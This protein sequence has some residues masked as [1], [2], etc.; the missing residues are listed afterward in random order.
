MEKSK[1]Y[2]VLQL[3]DVLRK[4]GFLRIS[5]CCGEYAISVATFRRYVAFLRGYFSEK[6][7]R[8]LIYDAARQ[9]YCLKWE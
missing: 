2:V 9:V 4:G 6:M 1:S 5:E 8:D 7:G 3:Y